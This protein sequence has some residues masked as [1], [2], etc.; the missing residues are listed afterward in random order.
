MLMPMTTKDVL[1]WFD[2]PGHP[3]VNN[4]AIQS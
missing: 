4:K 3:T 2:T 1:D